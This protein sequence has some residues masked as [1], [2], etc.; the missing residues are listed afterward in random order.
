[1]TKEKRKKGIEIFK[2]SAIARTN[3]KYISVWGRGGGK[4]LKER[5]EVDTETLFPLVDRPRPGEPPANCGAD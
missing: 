3:I 2:Y 5:E 4:S 1:M